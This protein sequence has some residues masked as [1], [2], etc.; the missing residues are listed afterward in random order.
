[1]QILLGWAGQWVNRTADPQ[2]SFFLFF[3]LFS[4]F[5]RREWYLIKHEKPKETDEGPSGEGRR[6]P[7]KAKKVEAT[8]NMVKYLRWPKTPFERRCIMRSRDWCVINCQWELTRSPL[9]FVSPIVIVI[10]IVIN[11]CHNIWYYHLSVQNAVPKTTNERRNK[12][13]SGRPSWW[14]VWAQ[15]RHPFDMICIVTSID[16]SIYRS[17][18]L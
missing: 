6:R 8:R 13:K 2:N 16:H 5:L 1:M 12:R 7:K 9:I 18:H 17:F 3:F 11:Y 15:T 14:H 4:F 10:V